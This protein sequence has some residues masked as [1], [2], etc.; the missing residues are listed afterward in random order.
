MRAIQ[1]LWWIDTSSTPS[2]E[3]ERIKEVRENTD[4][5]TRSDFVE[6]IKDLNHKRAAV[7]SQHL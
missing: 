2:S 5:G 1:M 6:E 7:P 4:S 3:E